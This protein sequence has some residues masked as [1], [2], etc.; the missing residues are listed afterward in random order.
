[1]RK[2]FCYALLNSKHIIMNVNIAPETGHFYITPTGFLVYARN[3]FSAATNWITDGKYSPVPYFLFC[4]SIELGFKA[5]IL[6][7]GEKLNFVKNKIGHNL[8]YALEKAISYSLED[9][10][11]I[12]PEE[13][14]QIQK[15]NA[16]YNDKGFE[17]FNIKNLFD[18]INLPDIEILGKYSEKLLRDIEH[19]ILSNA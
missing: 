1:M 7:K 6:A 11:S 9:F 3:Y 18:K 15:A 17:Y 14:K 10:V 12:T 4:R 13:K 2:E 16:Y 5:F 19:F 8:E